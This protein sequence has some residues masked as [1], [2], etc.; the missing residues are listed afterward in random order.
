MSAAPQP[1]AAICMSGPIGFISEDDGS[2]M[3]AAVG[4]VHGTHVVS[5]CSDGTVMGGAMGYQGCKVVVRAYERAT[6][7]DPKDV[8]SLVQIGI[9][10]V[11]S[12]RMPQARAAFD[13]ALAANPANVDALCAQQFVAQRDNRA[14]DADALAKQL[15]AVDGKCRDFTEGATVAVKHP[16]AV[17][18][19]AR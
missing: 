4:T 12:D 1:P 5:F 9:V 11:K 17:T 6:V 14:K 18:T 19:P 7:L 16:G 3:L 2:G 15:R 13:R 10:H 8:D